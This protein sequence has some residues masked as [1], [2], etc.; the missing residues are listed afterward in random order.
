MD[1]VAILSV[2]MVVASIIVFGFIGYKVKGW[3][4]KDAESHKE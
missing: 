3:I 1:E 2:L 4:E